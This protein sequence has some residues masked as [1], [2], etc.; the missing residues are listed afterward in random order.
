MTHP[1]DSERES[2]KIL[3]SIFC[4]IYFVT[5]IV[6]PIA[7]AISAK[8]SSTVSSSSSIDEFRELRSLVVAQGQQIAALQ[9]TVET[10]K[11]KSDNN[12]TSFITAFGVILAAFIGGFFAFKNQNEQ[13]KQGRLLKAVEL[14]MDSRSGYQADIRRKNLNVFLDD[15]TQKHLK[16]IKDEFAGPEF[17]DLHV[18]LAQSMS[19]KAST[20]EQV[21]GIWKSVLKGKKLFDKIEYLGS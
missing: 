6:S 20:P 9:A 12:A 19:E 18:A 16:T 8:S 3:F 11:K 13:A 21:L 14:I 5:F 2:M 1:Y 15:E 7:F 10:Y 4:G 17:T